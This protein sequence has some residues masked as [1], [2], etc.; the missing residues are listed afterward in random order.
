MHLV[1]R[2]DRVP[3]LGHDL[4]RDLEA[5]IHSLGADMEQEVAGRCD[6]VALS[7]PE[8]RKGWFGR[9]RL[10]EQPVPGVGPDA[11][12]AGKPGLEI[13]KFNGSNEA[14]K[15]TQNDR[16]KA[17]LSSPELIV[18]TRKI[19]ARVSGAVTAAER[20]RRALRC[21]GH[22][23]SP[24]FHVWTP[25]ADED[26]S[27]HDVWRTFP[28]S[29]MA[30]KPC[31]RRPRQAAASETAICDAAR[32]GDRAI[33]R[34]VVIVVSQSTNSTSS[35]RRVRLNRLQEFRMFANRRIV[36][37]SAL[38]LAT[39]AARADSL[40]NAAL[41]RKK[42]E[43]VEVEYRLRQAGQGKLRRRRA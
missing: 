7:G 41:L 2:C 36:T 32:P 16:T 12:H 37:I 29:P 43:T 35:F 38:L 18:T 30:F 14:G 9:P 21:V 15:V 20:R 4:R 1:D 11:H 33:G 3:E 13:A 31:A 17:R 24:R 34:S 42:A 26:L 23:L 40:Q 25:A 10:A 8:L 22:G 39:V 5:Q 28:D 19:A 27:F 6:R